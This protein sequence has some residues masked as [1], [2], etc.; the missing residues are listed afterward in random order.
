LHDWFA[1]AVTVKARSFF[2]LQLEQFQHPHGL[3]GGGH[4]LQLA[5]GPGQHETGG[6]DAQHL[7]AAVSQTR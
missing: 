7:D 1:A 6:P 2:G 5:I 4:H 3:T